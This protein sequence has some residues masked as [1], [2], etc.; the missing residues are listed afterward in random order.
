MSAFTCLIMTKH[1]RIISNGKGILDVTLDNQMDLIAN[2]SPE[3]IES[4]L[5]QTDEVSYFGKRPLGIVLPSTSSP[6]VMAKK[7]DP[8]LSTL[9]ERGFHLFQARVIDCLLDSEKIRQILK[10]KRFVII[11]TLEDHLGFIKGEFGGPIESFSGMPVIN[12]NRSLFNKVID[13]A[14]SMAN[15]PIEKFAIDI[16]KVEQQYFSQTTSWLNAGKSGPKNKALCQARVILQRYVG[17]LSVMV[18]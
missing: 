6:E 10:D 1:S 3:E 16:F 15:P 7:Y 5:E 2:F 4:I 11:H 17:I 18:I 12:R 14:I 8:I 13:V 9:K